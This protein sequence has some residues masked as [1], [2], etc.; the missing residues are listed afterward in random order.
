M[1]WSS[2]GFK[3][4]VLKHKRVSSLKFKMLRVV[5]DEQTDFPSD[6]ERFMIHES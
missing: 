2:L 4:E 1:R 3:I 6:Q 5:T